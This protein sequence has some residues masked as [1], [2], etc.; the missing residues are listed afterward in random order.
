MSNRILLDQEEL[1]KTTFATLDSIL[2]LSANLKVAGVGG[3][4]CTA[5]ES[6]IKRGLTGV[7]YIAINTDVQSL[8]SNPASVKIPIGTK[9]TK[10]L[11]A[12]A[13]PNVGRK[14]AEENKEQ[15]Q[16]ALKG[17][18]MVFVTA[19]MGGGTGTGAAPVVAQIAKSMGALVVAIVTK[20]FGFEGS[21]RSRNAEQ[22]IKELRQHVDS[23]IVIPN[24]RLFNIV[25]KNTNAFSAFDKANDILFEATRGIS[26]IIT[27]KGLINVDFADV[28][29][30]MS[31]SGIAVMGVGLTSGEN[32][33]VEAAQKAISSPLLEGMS[34]QGARSILVNMTGSETMTL[35]EVHEAMQVINSAVGTQDVNIIFGAVHKEDMKDFLSITVIATGFEHAE[36]KPKNVLSMSQITAS[37]QEPIQIPVAPPRFGGTIFVRPTDLNN[38]EAPTIGRMAANGATT[39]QAP[40]SGFSFNDVQNKSVEDFSRSSRPNNRADE[41]EATAS[42]FLRSLM[43]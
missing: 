27:V 9:L 16:D 35:F 20:P 13:D 39:Q 26:D 25:E 11:G 36:S 19:G 30:V 24:D 18:D 29:T 28:R 34:I 43:D 15:I 1:P 22:G 21:A 38:L 10:G 2:T 41:E 14:A 12:G 17:A 40:Q 42:S 5:V 33:A 6:M 37:K 8:N 4:G 31:A 23:L 7:E 32:R 3:G